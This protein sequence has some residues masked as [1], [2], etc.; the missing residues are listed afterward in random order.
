MK[1]LLALILIAPALTYAATR[2]EA[3]KCYIALNTTDGQVQTFQSEA[4]ASCA[5]SNNKDC[6]LDY[7]QNNFD[8]MKAELDKTWKEQIGKYFSNEEIYRC[9]YAVKEWK[10]EY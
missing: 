8:K 3:I 10:L 6:I 9:T 7:L 2:K 1:Y 4:L 5:N